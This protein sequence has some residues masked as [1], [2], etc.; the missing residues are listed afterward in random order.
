MGGYGAFIWPCYGLTALVMIILVV[1]SLRSMRT[2]EKL[3]ETLRAGR[4]RRRER[5]AD[6]AT[7]PELEAKA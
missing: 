4:A 2:N 7:K 5:T 1:Q 3:V 6:P